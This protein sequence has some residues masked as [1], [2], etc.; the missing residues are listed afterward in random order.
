MYSIQVQRKSAIPIK[1]QIYQKIR[2]QIF[3]GV[4]TA[5]VALPSTREL[6]EQIKVS[7]NTVCE[8]YEMLIAEGFVLHRQGAP[9][10]IAEGLQ[11]EIDLE[12][13]TEIK[14]IKK[15][16]YI[17]DFQTG[18]PDLKR[19]P[20]YLWQQ[21]MHKSVA[22][23]QLDD[24]GYSNP[25]GLIALRSEISAW[26]LRSKGLSVQEQDIFI[27]SGATQ[28]LHLISNLLG[29]HGNKI[30]IEDPCNQ[31][32]LK[33]ILNTGCSIEPI[34]VDE[35]GIQTEWL[36][37]TKVSAVY[38]TPSHQFPLGGIL[39]AVRRAALVRYAKANEAYLVEDDYDSEFRY[40]GDPIAPLYAMAPNKVIYIGTFSKTLFPAI[41]IGYVILPQELQADWCEL[42]LHTDVQNTP[43]E[44]AALA[45]FLRTRKFDR[46]IRSMKKLYGE[47]RMVLLE[48]LKFN[49][50]NTWRSWGDAAGL[51]LAIEFQ[52]ETFDSNFFERCKKNGLKITS[53]DYHGIQKGQHLNKL[54]LGY[55]HLEPE[56][57]QKGID[58]LRSVMK[59]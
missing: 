51:H 3:T 59:K 45:E 49:F 21:M 5:G 12:K 31:G 36:N 15:P 14:V 24:F 46:H 4:L 40:L 30:A 13:K 25:Q 50:A 52:K 18:R 39:P 26:L 29:G 9:T 7:R 32:V 38:T 27:S 17:V 2:D 57:I 33:T 23:L 19:F 43:F 58:I 37:K 35:H 47:R 20:Q 34:P 16:H 55:G 42:R 6:A 44:Q 41:R 8:A 48:A 1:R 28:A 54:L 53:V 10:R 11:L 56:A 22:A